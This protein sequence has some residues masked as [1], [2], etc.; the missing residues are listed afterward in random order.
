MAQHI[1]KSSLAWAQR[2]LGHAGS[3]S[4]VPLVI[5][6]PGAGV[7]VFWQL[8]VIKGLSERYDL[9]NVP[10]LGSSSGALVTAM[11][12]S[13]TC[14]DQAA[15]R[16]LELL[17]EN[18]VVNRSWGF[19]GI[20]GQIT[21]KW[22]QDMLPEDAGFRC[23]NGAAE[24]LVTTLPFLRTRSIT[25][26]TSKSDLINVVMASSHIPVVVDPRL[27]VSCRWRPVIDGG[28]W[29]LLQ[30]SVTEYLPPHAQKTLLVS[31]FEDPNVVQDLHI[32]RK[33]RPADL[34][35]M[36]SLW[37][38]G[39]RHAALLAERHHDVLEAATRPQL[40]HHHQAQGRSAHMLQGH[41]DLL[42][43]SQNVRQFGN[44]CSNSHGSS[45]GSISTTPVRGI[46][47]R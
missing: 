45:I 19:V 39:E 4:T 7:L 38:M 25:D 42:S 35:G 29:W 9:R 27:W 6:W 46:L 15:S 16:G 22:M 32:L 23:S 44:S 40:P 10:M 11:A 2:R 8:G 24:L 3:H 43:S 31:P 33:L 41:M 14:V 17:K 21:R 34:S 26:F 20:L 37:Q 18:G 1:L 5:S 28:L 36:Q 12:K 13:G 30:R 47:L